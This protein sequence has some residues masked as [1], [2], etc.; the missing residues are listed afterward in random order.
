MS[1]QATVPATVVTESLLQGP[2]LSCWPFLQKKKKKA[3]C[4]SLELPCQHASQLLLAARFMTHLVDSSHQ[5]SLK[6]SSH[7]R[8]GS[9]A[10]FISNGPLISSLQSYTHM[11]SV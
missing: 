7:V 5:L 8:K 6:H 11:G 4:L 2:R 9:I 1:S 10:F 3:L